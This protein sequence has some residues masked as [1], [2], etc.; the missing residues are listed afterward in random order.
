MLLRFKFWIFIFLAGLW[1]CSQASAYTANK[2]HF[3]FLSSGIYRVVVE[4][5]VP[6]LKQYREADVEFTS[7]KKAEQFYWALIRGADFYWNEPEGIQFVQN[8]QGPDPW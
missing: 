4:F 7:K 3:Y 1:V 5:T 6:E 2:V 8:R